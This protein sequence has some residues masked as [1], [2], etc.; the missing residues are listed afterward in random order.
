MKAR[1]TE[2]LY[3]QREPSC[4]PLQKRCSAKHGFALHV[5]NASLLRSHRRYLQD[6]SP[7]TL[8]CGRLG[9]AAG[10]ES[11]MPST[12]SLRGSNLLTP[13]WMWSW[14]LPPTAIQKAWQPPQR[15][16]SC[17]RAEGGSPAACFCGAGSSARPAGRAPGG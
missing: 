6:W 9:A 14:I 17:A 12:A 8:V 4:R 10:A 13:G 16:D 5:W 15:R 7:K 3:N 1:A 11:S 2:V